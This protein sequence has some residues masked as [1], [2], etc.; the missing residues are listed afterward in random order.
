MYRPILFTLVAFAAA[1]Q[2]ACSSSSSSPSDANPPR[3]VADASASDAPPSDAGPGDGAAG[4]G[5][6]SA[7]VTASGLS[8]APLGAGARRAWSQPDTTKPA[9]VLDVALTAWGDACRGRVPGEQ[10]T[11]LLYARA[12]TGPGTYPIKDTVVLGGDGAVGQFSMLEES[13]FDRSG[14]PDDVRPACGYDLATHTRWVDGSVTI[15]RLDAEAVEGSLEAR[16]AAGRVA[17]ATFR[18]PVCLSRTPG[19]IGCGS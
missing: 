7:S 18:A 8:F 6:A 17:R 5:G 15:V 9:D 4:D 3:P 10:K 19:T 12:V 14:W 16:D 2:V 13:T 11:L 1:C